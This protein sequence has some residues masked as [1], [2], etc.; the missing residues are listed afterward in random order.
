VHFPILSKRREQ[1]VAQSNLSALKLEET[2]SAPQ[3]AMGHIRSRK[4]LSKTSFMSQQTS[5]PGTGTGTCVSTFNAQ[6]GAK[7]QTMFLARMDYPKIAD[8]RQAAA[9]LHVEL[10]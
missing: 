8:P 4:S 7:K 6:P 3:F 9:Y 10:L 1:G 2:E 5:I